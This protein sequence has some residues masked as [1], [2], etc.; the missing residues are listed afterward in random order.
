M[1]RE[2]DMKRASMTWTVIGLVTF[3][4][5]TVTMNAFFRNRKHVASDSDGHVLTELWAD[6]RKSVAQDR[7]EKQAEVLSE[8]RRQSMERRLPWDFY[9]ASVRYVDAVSGIDWKKRDSLETEFADNV[10]KFGE[11]VVTFVWMA[12]NGKRADSL[13]RYVQEESK[14]LKNSHNNAFYGTGVQ[15]RH[16]TCAP[17]LSHFYA[18]DYEYAMWQLLSYKSDK[19][20]EGSIYEA[21]K[22]YEGKSYPLGAYLEYLEACSGTSA[23]G[24]QASL[25]AF[26]G[27]YA[28]KAM[29][30]L[31]E[32]DLL[33]MRMD[34]LMKA[35]APSSEYEALY[36]DCQQ[37]EKRRKAFHGDEAL[38]VDW[39]H[40]VEQLTRRLTC[41]DIDLNVRDGKLLV[42]LKNLEAVK[43]TVKAGSSA[44]PVIDKEL[45]NSV[46][47]FYVGDT[48]TVELPPLDDGTYSAEAKSGKDCRASIS[49][50]SY[51]ISV[52]VRTDSRGLCI[53]AADYRS[54]EPVGNVD[55]ELKKNGKTVAVHENF[56]LDG[57]TP[58]PEDFVSRM[59]GDVYYSLSCS[60]RG[61]DG[62]MQRSR[63]ISVNGNDMRPSGGTA[64]GNG[65]VRACGIFTDR[66]AYNPG[67]TVDFKAVIYYTDFIH[68]TEVSPAAARYKAVLVNAEGDEVESL[69]LM[70]NDF[71]SVAGRFVLPSDGK[72]GY[73]TIRV[74]TDP[75]VSYGS[76]SKSIR[77]D[78][79]VLPT[80][81]VVF[82]KVGKLYLPGDEVTV[83]GKVSSM[84]GHA[85]SSSRSVYEVESYGKRIASGSLEPAPDGSFS[86]KFVSESD[87][88]WSA[89]RVTVK[90]VDNTGETHEYGKTVYVS[91]SIR[92]NAELVNAS[93]A[94]V[95]DIRD[96]V[97]VFWKQA[98]CPSVLMDDMACVNLSV[99]SGDGADSPAEIAYRIENEKGKELMSASVLSG[100]EEKID[101]GSWPSGIYSLKAS[102]SLRSAD[103]KEYRDSTVLK[104]LLLRRGD[105]SLDAPVRDLIVPVN[106][107]V[108]PGD[109]ARV[110]F[111]MADG[112]PVWALAEVFGVDSELLE[113]RKVHLDGKR[114][115]SGSLEELSFAYPENWPEAV[116]IQIFYFRRGDVVST[117]YEF[118]RKHTEMELPLEFTSFEDRTLPS[119]LHTFTVR[120]RPDVE[121]LAAVFDKSSE[122]I[123]SNLWNA[124]RMRELHACYVHMDASAG[125]VGVNDWYGAVNYETVTADGRPGRRY[126]SD[127]LQ[128]RA[129]EAPMADALEES[130]AFDVGGG[131]A[132]TDEL[133][134]RKNF[135]NALTFQPFLRSDKDGNISF[136][137]RTSDKLSTYVVSLYAHD[138]SMA[139]A[140][141]RRE[142]MVTVPVKVDVS[143]PGYLYEGDS[144]RLAASVA[145]SS[146][147][148]VK[149]T[150]TLYVYGGKDYRALEAAGVKPI[151]MMSRQ[152]NV[153]AGSSV[154]EMFDVQEI[155]GGVSVSD[156]GFKLVFAAD[157]FSDGMFVSVP[158]R[159]AEQ[160]LVESHSAVLLAGMDKD[161]LVEKLRGEFVDV[162]G[163]D[164]EID[165]KNIIGMVRDA[166]PA[167]VEPSGKDVLSLSEAMYVRNLSGRLRALARMP[168]EE[169]PVMSDEELYGKVFACHNAD[170]GFGWFEGMK[171]SPVITAVLLERFSKMLSAGLLDPDAPVDDDAASAADVRA[172]LASAVHFLDS[173]Q[174]S[175]SGMCPGWCGGISGAQYMYIR[176]MFASVP[177]EVK[178]SGDRNIDRRLKDF[179]KDAKDYLV[180]KKE[181]GLN[182]CILEKARRIAAL[183][184]LYLSDDGQALAK[185]WGLGNIDSKMVKSADADVVSLLEYAVEHRD[186]GVYY[187][188]AVMPFRGLLENEA[189]AHSM[190]CDLLTAYALDKSVSPEASG[191]AVVKEA[192]RV[193]DGIRLWLMLQ[194][195]TQHWDAEPAFVDAVNS[196]MEGSRA[197]KSA[198]VVILKKTCTRPFRDIRAAGNGFSL[199]RRF[200]REAVSADGTVELQEIKSGEVL[201]VGDKIVAEYRMHN[202][203]NRSFVRVTVP[204]EAAFRPADQLSGRYGWWMSP[205]RV[206]GWYTF[207]PQGY[208][209][210]KTDRTEYWFDS[211]PEENT[212]ISEELFVVQSGRFT[213]PVPVVESLYAPHY[214]ANAGFP[215]AV[216][217]L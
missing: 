157:G 53:Y 102:V 25:Q 108:E 124:F 28:G 54:G 190:I 99:T 129:M 94:N 137:F 209:N 200:F 120:T 117:G 193:A 51:R 10:R 72:N 8:I 134:V 42:V 22:D 204:R 131:A 31:A 163:S 30:M 173:T 96:S 68:R 80:F 60:R 92:V 144:F 37:F 168:L 34:S 9:D 160:T 111:G 63:G 58:L 112:A 36:G 84:S 6:W 146:D 180:P 23:G 12:G 98:S 39:L 197:M 177:F 206:S 135:S 183:R 107:D 57:F 211:Y 202:D 139:N 62:L 47:S 113:T 192:L 176:S 104:I 40:D 48:M 147:R 97:R 126:K 138:K 35:K 50:D 169:A 78:E 212:V 128:A 149:G 188:N 170:G 55:I 207:V 88:S 159:P 145:S 46:R 167:K 187:P 103:G 181:R 43:V 81:D 24:K 4:L 198:S 123:E 164:A 130:V 215:G 195:E 186:G 118:R 201:S 172:V 26:A 41:K 27:K 152:V 14:L 90:I 20:C 79:L 89:Y 136:S 66:G 175:A 87:R 153:P 161:R 13:F 154:R 49:Y 115:K 2:K 82:D 21:L 101:M 143:A 73:Y 142:M 165:E 91:G 132:V 178:S 61:E 16:T 11:P 19:T 59:K 121:C 1:Q 77:V 17:F 33:G 76:F 38:V 7:P 156:F 191:S 71:G 174:F 189:Y 83:A 114:G 5:A 74:V 182:G 116:R 75:E 86:V 208:R 179:G 100:K 52:A 110:L 127:M 67:D 194:K 122:L 133:H 171:S 56:V 166:L 44:K 217:S 18:N 106:A 185:A 151:G 93:A 69:S 203:E 214:R 70:T 196:V 109:S 210:V 155:A 205:L 158:V 85:V 65:M 162:S 45:K 184:N 140:V 150:L 105:S 199:E 148:D 29:S 216:E 95:V 119:A 141:L 15:H 125:R 3:L 213:A 32:S 64:D